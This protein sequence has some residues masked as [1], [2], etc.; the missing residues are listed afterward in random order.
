M[1]TNTGTASDANGRFV[2]SKSGIK[3]TKLVLS[4]MGYRTDTVELKKELTKIDVQMVPAAINL[5][6]VEIKAKVGNTYISRLSPRKIQVITEGELQRAACCNLS[7][8]FETNASMDV[9]YSDA[10]TGAK[11][12]QLL[13]LSGIYSQIQAENIPSIRGYGFCLWI[14]LY[15]GS[16]DGVDPD[17]ER[18]CLRH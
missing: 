14:K 6:E 16:M 5:Q 18:N 15:P 12:I 17:F 13:G 9:S 2:L 1:G 4:L 11:Q 3:T 7:E 10:I 8:S